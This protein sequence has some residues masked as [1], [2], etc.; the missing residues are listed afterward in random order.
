LSSGW[1]YQAS[2]QKFLR[3]FENWMAR[4]QSCMRWYAAEF[5]GYCYG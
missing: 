2:F 1:H 3:N 5:Q 4:T